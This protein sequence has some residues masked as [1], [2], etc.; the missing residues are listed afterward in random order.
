MRRDECRVAVP[1]SSLLFSV[2]EAW[3]LMSWSYLFQKEK[4]NPLTLV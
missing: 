1:C 4:S 2:D 3:L